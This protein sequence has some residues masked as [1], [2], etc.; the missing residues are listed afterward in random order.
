MATVTV[1]SF[2][3]KGFVPNPPLPDIPDKNARLDKAMALAA[4]WGCDIRQANSN[5]YR[6]T[7]PLA[8]TMPRPVI[9]VSFSRKDT[10]QALVSYL[11]GIKRRVEAYWEREENLSGGLDPRPREMHIEPKELPVRNEMDDAIADAMEPALRLKNNGVHVREN[12]EP[13]VPMALADSKHPAVRDIVLARQKIR[14]IVKAK[15]GEIRELAAYVHYSDHCRDGFKPLHN[16]R[17]GRCQVLLGTLRELE[18]IDEHLNPTAFSIQMHLDEQDKLLEQ[19]LDE[20]TKPVPKPP[21]PVSVPAPVTETETTQTYTEGDFLAVLE[22]F[23]AQLTRVWR[24]PG[25]GPNRM[26]GRICDAIELWLRQERFHPRLMEFFKTNMWESLE[27]RIRSIRR[28]GGT[29]YIV[30]AST[31]RC[32]IEAVRRIES[33]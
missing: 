30:G 27:K 32:F 17:D 18:D 33:K 14:D 13:L 28:P 3:Q 9:P 4:E 24:V 12:L 7:H 25:G 2:H 21:E 20:I 11:R 23:R 5:D 31:W 15:L 19:A 29:N 22:H 26:T 6:V 16:C 10:S 1:K 8:T